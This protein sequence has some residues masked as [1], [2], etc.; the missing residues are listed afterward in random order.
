MTTFRMVTNLANKLVTGGLDCQ[1][2]EFTLSSTWSHAF[3]CFVFL[4]PVYLL[5]QVAKVADLQKT[6]LENE[7][8]LA[9]FSGKTHRLLHVLEIT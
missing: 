2:E 5:R 6:L 8:R 1:G 7:A 4:T 3:V 9:P